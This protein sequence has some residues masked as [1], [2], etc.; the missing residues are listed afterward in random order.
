MAFTTITAEDLVN[1]GVKNLADTPDMEASELKARFDSLADLAIDKIKAIVSELEADTASVSL[2]ASVPEGITATKNV[3]SIINAL[4][5]IV[6]QNAQNRHNHNN[7]EIL[8]TISEDVKSGYDQTVLKFEDIQSVEM[9]V[10]DSDTQ[11]PTS[12]AVVDYV[13][14]RIAQA[15]GH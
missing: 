15:L 8:E 12:G 4:N 10:N 5:M 3:Q 7:L 2:G 14:S 13:N 9:I 11:I 1:K 6:Q